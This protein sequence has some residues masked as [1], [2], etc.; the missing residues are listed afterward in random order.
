[1]SLKIPDLESTY[2][3][4]IPIFYCYSFILSYQFQYFN[5]FL[6]PMNWLLKRDNYLILF[7][8]TYRLHFIRSTH[9]QQKHYHTQLFSKLL[10]KHLPGPIGESI[11]VFTYHNA[12]CQDSTTYPICKK[13]LLFPVFEQSQ[14]KFFLHIYTKMD[15]FV[16]ICTRE[17]KSS[18]MHMNCVSFLQGVS[19]V[20]AWNYRV[21]G[22]KSKLREA[23]CS[24]RIRTT[25]KY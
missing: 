15:G 8:G 2:F 1:M 17:A 7:F 23:R 19:Q 24:K 16:Y 20:T 3:F 12:N 11:Q 25:F 10:S 4:P 14:L 6:W 22:I 9:F 21:K 18:D 13:I 5:I